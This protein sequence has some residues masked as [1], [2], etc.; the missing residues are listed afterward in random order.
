MQEITVELRFGNSAIAF[1]QIQKEWIQ[2][3]LCIVLLLELVESVATWGILMTAYN[4]H[5]S[6]FNN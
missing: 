1:F 4:G 6:Y 5:F 2:S 3:Y